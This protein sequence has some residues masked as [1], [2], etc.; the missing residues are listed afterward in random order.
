M[1]EIISIHRSILSLLFLFSSS[2][3]LFSPASFDIVDPL[4][5]RDNDAY[6]MTYLFSS[7]FFP[8]SD[9]KLVK[10]SVRMCV[11]VYMHTGRDRFKLLHLSLKLAS[12]RMPVDYALRPCSEQQQGVLQQQG[13]AKVNS[14]IPPLIGTFSR[15]SMG[16][17]QLW[18]LRDVVKRS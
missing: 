15:S 16:F 7:S 2:F 5:D 12:A 13:R 18:E 11:Y 17:N 14:E 1:Y 9:S 8:Y 6:R 10:T 3:L 4:L